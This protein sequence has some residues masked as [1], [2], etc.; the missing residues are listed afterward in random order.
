MNRKY[1]A[2]LVAALLALLTLFA[3]ACSEQNKPESNNASGK[4]NKPTTD[5]N[6]N[7]TPAVSNE[8]VDPLGKYPETITVTQVMGFSPPQDGKTP[9]SITPETNG[10]VTKLKEMLNIDIKYLWTVPSDQFEQKFSLSVASGDL[11]DVMAIGITDFEKFKEDGILADLTDAYNNYASPRLRQYVEQDGG[12]T[13]NLFKDENGK[14]LGLPNFED[15]YLSTQ[16]LWIRQDWLTQ[17][18]LEVPQT[19]EELEMVAEAFVKQDPDNNGKDDTVGIAIN[20]DLITWGFD[21]RG[22]FHTMGAYPKAWIKGPDGKLIAG[23]IQPE[24]RKALEKLQSWYQKGILDKEFAYKDINKVVEDVVAGKVGIAFGEWWYP[25]W[26]LNLNRD[27]DPKADWQ[28]YV[29]PSYDGKPGVPMIPKMRLSS[30]AVANKDMKNPEAMVKMAN[31]YL[32]MQ[33]PEYKDINKPENGFVYTWYQPR[34]YNPTDI[35][36]GYTTVNEALKTGKTDTLDPQHLSLYEKA[37]KYLEGDQSHWGMYTSRVDENG[38]WGLTQKI[39]EMPVIFNEF[40]GSPTPTQ[41]EKGA[42]LDKLTDETFT[43]IIVGSP[44]SDFD[45]YAESWKKLGGNDISE[46]INAWYEKTLQNQ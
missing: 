28:A 30:V 2:I 31:F 24:T 43:E 7:D 26:P 35:A 38:G 15:P 11:P 33:N 44:I 5:Q 6:T 27:K 25:E 18:N 37:K 9:K 17:L 16:I 21:A 20:K 40:A 10:Y 4:E 36:D 8:P 39:K 13:L 23:E 34:F 14:I 22:L 42:S 29:L 32:E 46:E 19:L 12:A 1:G 45:K 3:S 41:I